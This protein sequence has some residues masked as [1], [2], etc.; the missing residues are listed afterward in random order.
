MSD[1]YAGIGVADPY[2][3]I[4]APA[5]KT[6]KGKDAAKGFGSGV[7]R[8]AMGVV[9]AGLAATPFGAVPNALNMATGQNPVTGRFRASS[10]IAPHASRMAEYKPETGGGKVAQTAGAMSLNAFA[11]GNALTRMANVLLPT[12]G[13]EI[14]AGVVRAGGGDERAQDVA[15]GVGGLTGSGAASVRVRMPKPAPRAKA[16]PIGDVRARLKGETQA[17]Y[18]AVD[19]AGHRFSPKDSRAL[20]RDVTSLV[21]SEGGAGI[22][23]KA[24]A[25]ARRVQSVLGQKGGVSL[26]QLDKLRSQ[27]GEVLGKGSDAE[28]R[29]GGLIREKIDGFIDASGAP[30][31][32]AARAANTRYRK[33]ADVEDAI[34]SAALQAG[35]T[36]SG[37]NINNA[38]RQKLRPYIDPKSSQ[39]IRNLTPEEQNALRRVV[40]GTPGQNALR[41]VGK[42]SPE[43]NGLMQTVHALM[44]AGGFKTGGV[45]AGASAAM[46]VSGAIAKRVADRQ[47]AKNVDRLVQIIA[48]GGKEAPQAR[49]QFESLAKRNPDVASI[50]REV[51]PI[52]NAGTAFQP[53]PAAR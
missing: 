52:L 44:L 42:L 34:E 25:M 45:S 21:Q 2:A 14:A 31:L 40:V 37:G 5:P 24:A 26:T 49:V 39:R 20:S 19:S 53:A 16:E 18:Q 11:P 43:G 48:A 27:V 36:Y 46:A 41:Q 47:T 35:S 9:D 3:G 32:R 38:T 6:S 7:L 17:A 8:S 33:V 13:A 15:R 10:L 50:Y 51:I 30:E 23:P 4:G 1:P 29:I 22:Y 12:A 28:A